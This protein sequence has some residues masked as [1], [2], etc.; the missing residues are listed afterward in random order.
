MLMSKLSFWNRLKEVVS[1]I[2]NKLNRFIG[3]ILDF[4]WVF[5]FFFNFFIGFK[6]N[7]LTGIGKTD[8]LLFLRAEARRF[9]ENNTYAYYYFMIFRKK[10]F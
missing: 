8:Q 7:K 3:K 9:C 1:E 4:S 5:D 2:L 10:S 6:D